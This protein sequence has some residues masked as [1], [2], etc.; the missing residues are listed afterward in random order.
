MHYNIKMSSCTELFDMFVN[1][2]KGFRKFTIA[3]ESD[4][5]TCILKLTGKS[6]AVYKNVF[7]DQDELNNVI[8]KSTYFVIS[9][10]ISMTS[11]K[12]VP[13]NIIYNKIPPSEDL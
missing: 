7:K 10:K 9:S 6:P 8:I 11:V 1:N 2:S 3:N 4:Q 12:F 5:P 13:N